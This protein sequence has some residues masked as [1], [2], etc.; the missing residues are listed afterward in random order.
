MDKKYLE[1]I[2]KNKENSDSYYKKS[3]NKTEQQKFLEKY[4]LEDLNVDVT[5]NYNIADIACGYGT[6]TYHLCK[7]FEKAKYY[8]VDLNDEA[9]E[10]A[11]IINNDLNANYIVESCYEMK[12]IKDNTMDMVFCLQTLAWLDDPEKCLDELLRISKQ[13]GNIF[14]TSLFN[15]DYDCDLYVK[16]RDYTK[17]EN[18]LINYNTFSFIT[19][20]R[21]LQKHNVQ[22]VEL[23]PFEIKITLEKTTRGMGTHTIETKD[24]KLLQVS[25]GYLM[26]WGVLHIIK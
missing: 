5:K 15:Y 14:V 21:W 12:S 26:N 25:G 2:K 10:K 23:H 8:L 19:I 4:L 16:V 20:Q 13:G 7:I 24:G 17:D 6:C 11:K 1:F 3:I 18:Y 22:K 9:I